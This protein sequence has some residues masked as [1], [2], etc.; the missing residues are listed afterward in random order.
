[1]TPYLSIV[2]GIG[3]QLTQDLLGRLRTSLDNTAT[4][5]KAFKVPIEIVIVEWN[6][7]GTF[8]GHPFEGVPVRIIRTPS[9][10]HSQVPNPHGFKYFEWYPKNIGI[11]RAN[12]RFVLSTNPDDIFSVAMFE[13]FA[14]QELQE[15]HFYRA[16]R[17]DTHDGAVYRIC[18]ATGVFP[19]G[20][21][22]E[23]IRTQI[24]P[25]ACKWSPDMIHYNA[26]GDFTLMSK[27]DWFKIRGNPER[28]Y[29]H[30]VDGQTLWL[31]HINGL[32]QIV[33]P[34]P[35]YHP[36]HVR[37]LNHAYAPPWDDKTPHTSQ[38]NE[39]WGF[40]G[41]EFEESVL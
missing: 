1:M 8:S 17:H 4:L 6:M 26:S 27:A 40:A 10:L 16:N 18:H 31:A 41:M 21:P 9:E 38:N 19:P 30:S 22:E 7:P 36:D 12:G 34:Y 3:G 15:G 2:M 13:Y 24:A 23:T 25:G 28:D 29:N 14:K 37:T 20:T 33:L 11:R 5:A 35:I 39:S 32:K